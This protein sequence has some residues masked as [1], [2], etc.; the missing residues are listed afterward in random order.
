MSLSE[1]WTHYE[2]LTNELEQFS[3][4]LIKRPQ[5]IVANKID[6]PMAKENLEQLREKL[7]NIPVI[8]ISAKHGTNIEQ[9]L[10]DI[11]TV[12]DEYRIKN[13]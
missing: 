5:I 1:S 9:L 6:L 11:R 3:M 4:E 8:P 13:K 10:Q 12:Y 2:M 7:K